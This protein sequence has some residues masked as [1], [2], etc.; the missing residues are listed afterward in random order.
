[1]LHMVLQEVSSSKCFGG[2]QKVYKH[3]SYTVNCAMKFSVYLP[4]TYDTLA[5]LPVVFFL[6][7]L[8]CTEQNFI[9]KSGAQRTAARLGLILV[10]P[11]T[12][13]RGC[14]IPGEDDSY[15]FGSGA[16][17]YVNAT[18]GPWSAHYHIMGG[19]G[20]LI[21]GL[22]EAD[23]FVSVSAF[24]PI[25]HSSVSP[26]GIKAF[27]GELAF[28][29]YL[30]A[31][32]DWSMYDAVE[33]IIKHKKRFARTPLIDQ[34]D[35]DEWL[36]KQLMPSD[37]E[38]VCAAVGQDLTLRYQKGYDHSYFFIST[39]MEDHLNFHAKNLSE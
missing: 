22:R 25:C 27:T 2:Q 24:A 6:Q 12:S 8:T 19:H 18:Q 39:F 11:D 37:L 30:G 32:A 14:N 23:R 5:N 3:E 13:P 7:G 34:G 38:K 31:D 33:L 28:I 26:W 10:S 9:I 4:P 1:M 35:Q 20:A 21:V 36:E 17:F 16:G 29:C 15:D